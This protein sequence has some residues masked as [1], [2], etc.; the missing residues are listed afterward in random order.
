MR[1]EVRTELSGREN[2]E[3][4]NIREKDR[5][6]E[7]DEESYGRESEGNEDE[8]EARERN[9]SRLPLPDKEARQAG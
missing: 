2:R 9:G 4:T 1:V 8:G 3:D 7:R 5:M 6:K